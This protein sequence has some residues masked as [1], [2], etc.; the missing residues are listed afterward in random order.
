MKRSALFLLLILSL[1]IILPACQESKW[2][3]WKLQNDLWMENNKKQPGVITTASGLQYKVIHQG[4][5]RHPGNN[6][7]STVLLN[8]RGTLIDGSTFDQATKA[9][10]YVSTLV[11]GMQEGLLKMNGGGTYVLYIPY[12]LGYDTATTYS[13]NEVIPP[14]SNLIFEVDLVDSQN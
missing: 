7:S 14:Y 8:Y 3:D 5:Q 12:K 9:S 1:T 4:Y 13:T 6:S 10:F 2:A 11:K